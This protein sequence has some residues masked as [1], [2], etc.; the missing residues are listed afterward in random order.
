MFFCAGW[1]MSWVGLVLGDRW[2]G[3]FV[4]AIVSFFLGE[5]STAASCSRLVAG[6]SDDR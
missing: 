3:Y 6:V 5:F 1:L 4:F 2:M